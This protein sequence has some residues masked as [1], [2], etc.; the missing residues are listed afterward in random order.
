MGPIR[1]VVFPDIGR[2]GAKLQ[3]ACAADDGNYNWDPL[4]LLPSRPLAG[5]VASEASRV[6]GLLLARSKNSPPT[7]P[8]F[9]SLMRST[10]PANGREGIAI[11]MCAFPSP[12]QGKEVS[13]PLL[14]VA[15]PERGF[16]LAAYLHGGIV[17]VV[18]DVVPA[19][20]RAERDVLFDA[21]I[22]REPER[23]QAVI[24]RAFGRRL[25][26]PDAEAAFAVEHLARLEIAFGGRHRV[27]AE[28]GR[29][30]GRL[31]AQRR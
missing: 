18:V 30:A 11:A 10:L 23:Q 2:A 8:A 9:A 7:P 3:G 12:L 31:I 21:D 16:H 19:Q 29:H 22:V 5:R 4:L 25:A 6:G 27:G 24:E 20:R 14:R 28:T 17:G 13:P 15:P 1:P 26:A